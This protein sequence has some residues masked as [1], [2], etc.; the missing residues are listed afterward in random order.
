MEIKKQEKIEEIKRFTGIIP[1]RIVALNPTLEELHKLGYTYLTQEPVYTTDDGG[2]RL[3][4]M[5]ENASGMDY[6][7]NGALV[8]SGKLVN[9][10]SIFLKPGN[11]G[12]S[13]GK[14]MIVNDLL[15]HSWSTDLETLMS[16]ER[17]EW[18]SKNH[19]IR[20]AKE[21]EVDLLVLFR[22]LCGLSL[23]SKEKSADE[24]KFKT[25]WAEI[26]NGNLTEL[27]G[28]ITQAFKSGNGVTFLQGVKTTPEGKM[29]STLYTKH[30]QTATNKQTKMFEKAL[31][32][33]TPNNFDYQDSLKF[34]LYTGTSTPKADAAQTV[35]SDW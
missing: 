16:N 22:T 34:Q 9:K 14:V 32:D 10:H 3:D 11:Q 17:M 6:L 13:T 28:Y 31:A 25:T 19:N 15:Q 18:F 21:G 20:V 30:I 24:V 27:R 1:Y 26:L 4:F 7:E 23:G 12:S 35:K 5:L 33:Y 2:L 8:N 29:Y